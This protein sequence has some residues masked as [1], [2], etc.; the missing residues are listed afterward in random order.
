[1]PQIITVLILISVVFSVCNQEAESVDQKMIMANHRIRW[2]LFDDSAQLVV[3]SIL[4]SSG[5][6]LEVL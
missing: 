3:V 6:L 4:H 2:F 1:M 5:T